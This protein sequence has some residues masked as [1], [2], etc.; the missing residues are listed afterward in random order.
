MADPVLRAAN[1][2]DASAIA[3]LIA[4][5]ARG[6]CGRDY[7]SAQIEA[8]LGTAWGCDTEL[9]RDGTYFVAETAAELVACGG[10]GKRRTLFG[11]GARPGRQSELLD[12]A[13]EAAR[14]RAFFVHPEW[15]GKGLAAA[16]LAR[17]EAEARR[18]GFA[19]AEL[20]AILTGVPF[21]AKHGYT[22]GPAFDHP[23]PCGLTIRLVPMRRRLGPSPFGA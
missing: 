12:P 19:E 17:S 7:T 23:L 8:A 20:A 15:A 6:L 9:I 16:L 21:Y 1:L 22:A 11:G 14:I 3:S 10:W 18:H 2:A 13:H 4:A 5:S